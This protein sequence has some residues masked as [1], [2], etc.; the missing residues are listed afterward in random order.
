[1]VRQP[2]RDIKG[3]LF[4]LDETLIDAVKGLEAAH[5]AVTEKICEYFPC[6]QTG[7]SKQTISNQ[8]SDFD[9]QKN[10]ERKYNRDLW[11]QEFLKK[12]GIDENITESQIKELTETY[13]NN[14]VKNAK[15][16]PNS[17]DVLTYLSGKNYSLG[18]VTD[19][20]GSGIP[21]RERI[22]RLD[23]SNLFETI[24]IGGK[25]TPKSKPDPECFKLAAK[26]LGL[27][28]IEC[29]M[30]GDKPFTDIKGA[31]S[32][33][34]KTILFKQREWGNEE[35]PDFVIQSLEEIKTLL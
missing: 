33:G 3:V 24:V 30:I 7:L 22:S 4:D 18:L 8:L 29:V 34:M 23:F 10:L 5:Q 25:D 13:W 15:P 11:W 21:K 32:V 16:Y 17:K 35:N 2:L 28:P 12:V 31:N 14:Y 27:S 9:D 20:D 6:E 1:M 26:Q 19:T